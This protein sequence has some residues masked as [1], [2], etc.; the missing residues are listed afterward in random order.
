[1][2][3]LEQ[4]VEKTEEQYLLEG[5]DIH[6]KEQSKAILRQKKLQQ[7]NAKNQEGGTGR[8]IKTLHE[9]HSGVLGYIDKA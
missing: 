7:Q 1:M 8:N 6:D 4:I 9:V 2:R 5:I 3:P